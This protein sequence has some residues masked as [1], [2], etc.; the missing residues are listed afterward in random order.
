MSGD[1]RALTSLAPMPLV[2]EK[3][4]Y[5]G[6]QQ[7]QKQKQKQ[8]K[9]KQQQLSAD[10]QQDA[11]ETD[12]QEELEDEDIIQQKKLDNDEKNVRVLHIDEYV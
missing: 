9:K 7:K 12:A 5:P 1:I 8:H 10:E 4:H 3:R 11:D 6:E 2:R